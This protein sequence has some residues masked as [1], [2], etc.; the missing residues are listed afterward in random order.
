MTSGILVVSL[1]LASLL[2]Y[3]ETAAK[4][5]NI[6]SVILCVA[7]IVLANIK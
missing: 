3:K 5:R 2:I 7:A 1:W 6:V 4:P